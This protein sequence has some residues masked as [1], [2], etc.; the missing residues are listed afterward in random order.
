VREGQCKAKRIRAETCSSGKA[1][2]MEAQEGNNGE[3]GRAMEKHKEHLVL[4]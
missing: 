3:N 2:E 1:L 4:P